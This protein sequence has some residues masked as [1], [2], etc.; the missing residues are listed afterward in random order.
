MNSKKILWGVLAMMLMVLTACGD[1]DDQPGDTDAAKQKLTSMTSYGQTL[2]SFK[3][4]N[5]GR[6]TRLKVEELIINIS[7]SPLKMEFIDEDEV[8]EWNDIVT[9]SDGYI[10]SAKLTETYEGEVDTWNVSVSY[11]RDNYM[12]LAKDGDNSPT[13]LEWNGSRL[14]NIRMYDDHYVYT[15]TLTYSNTENRAEN[16]SLMWCEMSLY[17]LTGLFGKVPGYLPSQVYDSDSDET[18]K[19]AYKLNSNGSIAKEQVTFEGEYPAVIDYNYS[20]SRASVCDDATSADPFRIY[21]TK[22]AKK[23]RL[24]HKR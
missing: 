1:D 2:A 16:V 17:W 6:I 15:Q 20:S 19:L 24:F 5:Q 12:T 8:T 3:Y 18:V 22:V 10:T 23:N 7:Y 9:N 21:S 14:E 11:N 4:D 13:T